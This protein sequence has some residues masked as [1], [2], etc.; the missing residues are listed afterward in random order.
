[1]TTLPATPPAEAGDDIQLTPDGRLRHLLTLRGLGREQLFAILDR[2]EQYLAPPDQPVVRSDALAGRTVA[3]L[4]FEPSTR[5]RA[6]FELAAKRLSADVLNLDVSTSSRIKGESILD[7][8]YTLQAM[9]CDVFVVRDAAVD[10]PRMIAGAVREGVAI[11]NAGEATVAHPTQ[12]LLDLLTVRRARPDLEALRICIVGDIAHSRVARSA[13]EAFTTAG[14]A[15]LRLVAP[16][17]LQP[18]AAAFPGA[19]LHDR[20]D[21]GVEDADVV[22]ALR[23]QRERIA[24]AGDIPDTADYAR[25]Y[26]L[27]ESNLAPAKP[28]VLVMHPGPMNRG[29]EIDDETADSPRSLITEQVRNGVAVRMALL[30]MITET[31]AGGAA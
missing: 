12:G 2:A 25:R 11:L 6:S 5:T 4:F 7:T 10:V 17:R 16:E 30:E 20:L 3:N 26:G 24:D 1:M 23:I 22:M 19:T 31:H 21:E 29:V 15:E 8:I 14:V 13:A 18:D 28:D 9:H 27:T